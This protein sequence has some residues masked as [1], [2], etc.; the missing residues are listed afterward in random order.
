MSYDTLDA[1]ITLTDRVGD[2]AA[3]INVLEPGLD[4]LRQEVIERIGKLQNAVDSL[5]D[6]VQV[7]FA[8]RSRVEE[9][10]R[11]AVDQTRWLADRVNAMERRILD[12]SA[13]VAK[14]ESKVAMTQSTS[15]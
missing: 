10:A 5:R 2:L 15:C 14:L 1:I 8:S 4:R 3:R 11:H 12:L 6:D 9:T 13:R 7:G